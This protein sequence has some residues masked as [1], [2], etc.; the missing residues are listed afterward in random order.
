MIFETML[1]LPP[2]TRDVQ[3]RYST[4]EEA[5][6]GHADLLRRAKENVLEF[7]EEDE[8]E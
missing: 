7:L 1:F 8:A 5:Q 4:L 3:Q 6:A 2:T